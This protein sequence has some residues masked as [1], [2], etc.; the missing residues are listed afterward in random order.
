MSDIVMLKGVRV[1]FPYLFKKNKFEKYGAVLMLENETDVK[2][3]QK[4][5]ADKIKH[6]FKGKGIPADKIC[7]KNGDDSGNDAY[8]GLHFLNT[9][10]STRPKVLNAKADVITDAE[11]DKIYSG[12]YVNA[13]VSVWAQNN[14]YGKRI[15]CELIAIQ[16]AKNGE[17]LGGKGVS[18]SEATEGFEAV[19][20][21]DD[22][23]AA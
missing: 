18:V 8:E 4:V 19:E 16:F 5:I 17:E 3:V 13:K 20:E 2:R 1:N 7:L 14:D 15:N 21:D 6:D 23:L 10:A 9:N 11:E 22:F 12:C